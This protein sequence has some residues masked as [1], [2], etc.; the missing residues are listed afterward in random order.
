MIDGDYGKHKLTVCAHLSNLFNSYSV[1][2]GR[3]MPNYWDVDRWS[4]KQLKKPK[5]GRQDNDEESLQRGTCLLMKSLSTS[6]IPSLP[7]AK[8][9]KRI[10][11]NFDKEVAH[12]MFGY[13]LSL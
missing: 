9:A 6:H 13:R 10:Y 11:A 2:Y 4:S 8:D 5:K 3:P 1:I 12:K 7:K